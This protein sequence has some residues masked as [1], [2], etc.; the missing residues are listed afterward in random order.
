[1]KMIQCFGGIG[2]NVVDVSPQFVAAN[3]SAFQTYV[4]F[5]PVKHANFRPRDSV[6]ANGDLV[7][8]RRI[9]IEAA[10]KALSEAKDETAEAAAIADLQAAEALPP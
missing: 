3:T 1:M 6:K 7:S 10:E 2:A 8:T 5:D 9:A 4:P